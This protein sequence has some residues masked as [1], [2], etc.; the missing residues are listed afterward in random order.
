MPKLDAVGVVV[1]DLQKAKEFYSLLGLQLEFTEGEEHTELISTGGL[2]IMFD[3]ET[4]I[5]SFSDHDVTKV[6][7]QRVSLAFLCDSV[8]EVDATYEAVVA[9]GFTG[10]LKP[11]DAVWG[12]RRRKSGR[13]VCQ[14]ANC[15][16][17]S[18]VLQEWGI[19]K[20]ADNLRLFT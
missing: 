2:R 14:S 16:V 18:C 8:A 11:W 7:F 9:A 17:V 20:A 13:S 12:M 5:Q 10:V 15:L 1:K 6:G 19:A 4:M 3:T